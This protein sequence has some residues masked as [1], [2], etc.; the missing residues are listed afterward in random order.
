MKDTILAALACV[1]LC[2]AIPTFAAVYGNAQ[3]QQPEQQT[4]QTEGTQETMP[5]AQ[6]DTQ[7]AMAQP[8][9]ATEKQ[10]NTQ[11]VG[12]DEAFNLPVLFSQGVDSLSLHE[13]LVGAITGEMPLS[14]DLE[15][16]KAQAI[17]CRTYALRQYG[18][19]KH[20]PAAVCTA[21]S[22]CECWVS[23]ADT[24]AELL[25]K[26]ERAVTETDGMV[27][28]YDG[29]LIEATFF[30]CSGGRTESAEDVW[31][32]AIPYLVAVDSPGEE[33]APRYTGS[34]EVSRQEFQDKIT[35]ADAAADF[36]ADAGQWVSNMT[37]T[38]GGGVRT[39]NIG[40]IPLTG[41]QLRKLFGL[42][43]TNFKIDIQAESVVF[44]TIGYGHRVG[45]SQYG[46]Q[47]MAEAGADCLTI[48]QHYYTGA[49]VIDGHTIYPQL[50]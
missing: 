19:R 28:A 14:F 30:S 23:T 25:A 4:Q 49:E 35:Q 46:A 6:A 10:I 5:Q 48:L 47:A 32:N 20:D 45:M 18:G 36:S 38:T 37:Y 9:Q 12:F 3:T 16:L 44:Q 39:V 41:K 8:M 33:A 22:C 17:A 15:A 26:A 29:S 27:L 42:N 40:G 43:S 13:Y 2:M 31:G 34:I 11:S 21:S 1:L 50:P 7:E 24:Q